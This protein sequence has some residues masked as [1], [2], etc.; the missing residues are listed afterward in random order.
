MITIG[1]PKSTADYSKTAGLLHYRQTE[2]CVI[3]QLG[4][5]RSGDT[6]YIR[7]MIG[8]YYTGGTR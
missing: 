2:V 7:Y 4:F 1:G 5:V 6:L 8:K 3:G